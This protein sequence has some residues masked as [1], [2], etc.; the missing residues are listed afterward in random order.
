MTGTREH[1]ILQHNLVQICSSSDC[2][3]RNPCPRY[4]YLSLCCSGFQWNPF[5]ELNFVNLVLR[6]SNL[7][8]SSQ[9]S[10]WKK[11]QSLCLIFENLDDVE[12]YTSHCNRFGDSGAGGTAEHW[13]KFRFLGRFSL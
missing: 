3:N 12:S 13:L 6:L 11:F 1:I 8:I 10:E 5:K 4:A 9:V 7:S 2:P